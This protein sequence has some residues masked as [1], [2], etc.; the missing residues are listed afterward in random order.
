M[1]TNLNTIS[2]TL[3]DGSQIRC[4]IGTR[5]RDIQPQHRSPEGLEYI[6]ALVNNDAV[7][8]SYPVEVDSSV[9][10]LTRGDPQGFQIYYRSACFLLAKTVKDLFPDARFAVQHSLG[11]GFY[12]SFEM[13]GSAGISEEQLQTIDKQMRA[14]VERDVPI[15]RRKISFTKAV[16]RFEQEKQ[17]D[18]YNLLR[19]RNPP[20]VATWWCENFSDLDHG[21]LAGSTGAL[22]TFKLIPY[23]P[24]FV[25][26]IPAPE[27]PKELPPF[28]PQPQLFQIFKEHKEW[29]RILGV[30]T[31]GRLNEIIANREI[32]EFIRTAEAF[33]EKKIAQIADHIYEHREHIK[34]A[35]IAGPSSS[36]KTTFAKR[37]AVQLRVN[38]LRPVT[39]SVDNY[40]VNREQTP[41]D[42]AGKPDFEN[43]ETVDLPLFN[44]HLMRLDKGEEVDLPSFDF[45]K[46]CRGDRS[47]K[48]RI[49]PDQIVLLEGIHGL[50]PRLT[51]SLPA[52]HKMRI[53]ISAL[54]QLNLDSNNRIST[55]DNRLVRRMVR[56][57]NFRGNSALATL[58]MWPSVRRGEKT[59][60]FPYQQEADIAFNS[61]LDY[62]LAV[63]KPFVEPLLA[64]VKPYHP[65]YAEARRLL[66]FLSSFLS[67]SDHFVPPTS[68]LRE[69]IGHSSFRY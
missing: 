20:K 25:L 5:V 58:N 50:N 38:G 26:Q 30:N 53:Y 63:L 1:D 8:L 37:L 52:S 19:F 39:I 45:E 14:I 29:G 11:T 3:A 15:E 62:E 17:L 46:G 57:N 23:P 40:F 47:Q 13:N 59:W 54:T 51:E 28:E 24:G 42:E 61:A 16:S 18:K 41:L 64:E 48:L 43:I 22:T 35:L 7:S 6:G 65:Q 10:L 31:V 4:A 9:R 68:I 49:E 69:F 32:G 34:W 27:N 66:E 33:H 21:P 67:V 12:C 2:V 36:G 44:D 55:T 60:I 56:D